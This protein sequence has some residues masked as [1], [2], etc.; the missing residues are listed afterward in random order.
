LKFLKNKTVTKAKN[1]S[2]FF[3]LPVGYS[4]DAFSG[5]QVRRQITQER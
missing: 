4:G 3:S 5:A 2:K 1:E